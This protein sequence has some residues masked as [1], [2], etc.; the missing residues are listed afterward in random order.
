VLEGR[1]RV[2]FELPD[3]IERI[4]S[5]VPAGPPL[6]RAAA[7]G[8]ALRA[9]IMAA[10]RNGR[11]FDWMHTAHFPVPR[12][13]AI[14]FTLTI[15]DLRSLSLRG[16]PLPR[17]IL[18]GPV[19]GGAARR[20]ARVFTVS[21][22]T[23][24]DIAARLRVPDACVIGNGGDHFQP[25]ERR[26]QA[27]APLVHVG[28]L[29]PRKNVDLLLH[30]LKLDAALPALELW[31]AAKAGEAER[32][33]ALARKL[34]VDA[35]VR[36]RGPY[37]ETICR[38]SWPPAPP[39]CCRRDSRASASPSSRRSALSHRWRSRTRRAARSRGSGRPAVR[40]R[41]RH[42]L[43]GGDPSGLVT[44][45]GRSAARCGT[46][47]RVHLDRAAWSWFEGWLAV[48]YRPASS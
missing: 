6:A 18:A 25:M 16:A 11:P 33:A 12:G 29:E 9:A 28:H 39:S 2:A 45:R 43:R 36:I 17:R 35:R 4:A 40:S 44:L 14:P 31:G 46:G 34:G 20:A 26:A 42:R 32:L 41:R 22:S 1:E 7:E 23:A 27:G 47:Q 8:H 38:R 15:H 24:R 21:E 19:I 13:I 10:A 48:G 5:S 37:E 3:P 30:A